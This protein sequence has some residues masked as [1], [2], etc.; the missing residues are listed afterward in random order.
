MAHADDSDAASATV[1]QPA[2]PKPQR[3]AR[4]EGPAIGRA[5]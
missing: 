2:A 3:T 5:R 1:M 4:A